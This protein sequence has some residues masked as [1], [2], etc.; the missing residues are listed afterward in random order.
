M[1]I[2]IKVDLIAELKSRADTYK[3]D[4]LKKL[5]PAL[6]SQQVVQVLSV[7]DADTYRKDALKVLKSCVEIKDVVNILHG[8]SSDTYKKDALKILEYKLP[9][10]DYD[11]VWTI[12]KSFSA[13]TYKKDALKIISKKLQP[14]IEDAA[15]QILS[16]FGSDTY[17]ADG[18]TIIAPYFLKADGH[19]A[20]RITGMVGNAYKKS[21][22]KHFKG[23]MPDEVFDAT[24]EEYEKEAN[25]GTIIMNG[26]NMC[27]ISMVTDSGGSI[28]MSGA[29]QGYTG[30]LTQSLMVYTRNGRE[31][32]LGPMHIIR[33][34]G[35]YRLQITQPS[36][37]EIRIKGLG[38]HQLTIQGQIYTPSFSQCSVSGVSIDLDCIGIMTI[39]DTIAGHRLKIETTAAKT[40]TLTLIDGTWDLPEWINYNVNLKFK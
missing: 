31:I 26:V 33:N 3:V 22:Y 40:I 12:I 13:D 34:G 23:C 21:V 37:N 6:S 15:H 29:P 18:V 4:Y 10:L 32:V 8:F 19:F 2:E 28:T 1:Q 27:G 24:M 16:C 20:D 36:S 14:L 5:N 39:T 38:D 9:S 7:F 11:F 17:I 35:T 25:K 30:D